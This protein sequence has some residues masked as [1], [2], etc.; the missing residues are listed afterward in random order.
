MI[1]EGDTVA[2]VETGEQFT[3]LH[4]NQAGMAMV[5]D[6]NGLLSYYKNDQLKLVK[7]RNKE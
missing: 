7:K 5:K 4:L 2:H 1:Q 3:F 6:K